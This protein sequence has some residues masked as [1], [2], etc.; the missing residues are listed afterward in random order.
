M[1]TKEHLDFILADLQQRREYWLDIVRENYKIWNENGQEGSIA[2]EK[3]LDRFETQIQ[4]IRYVM[5]ESEYL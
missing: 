1:R 4:T 3:E 2:G 5:G